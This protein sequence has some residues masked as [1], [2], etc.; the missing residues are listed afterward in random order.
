MVNHLIRDANIAFGFI[1]QPFARAG[2]DGARR[3]FI[4]GLAVMVSGSLVLAQAGRVAL[5]QAKLTEPPRLRKARVP[6]QPLNPI[7]GGEVVL[8]LTVTA[9]GAVSGVKR[10]RTTPPYTDFLADAVATWQ[11][12]PAIATF[13]K[14]EVAVDYRRRPCRR[15][16]RN[17]RTRPTASLSGDQSVIRLRQRSP[18]G[19]AG[20][21]LHATH[22]RTADTLRVCGA[23]L[24]LTD[25]TNRAAAQQLKQLITPR[26]ETRA[27]SGAP[28]AAQRR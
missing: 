7:G 9:S 22:Q 28:P 18:C 5:A 10:L 11:S 12:T 20:V 1:A 16:D 23:G 17:E 14:Q 3:R 21:A 26:R 15:R 24:P 2:G 4:V 13:E 19:G 27:W 6:G 25:G 8:E